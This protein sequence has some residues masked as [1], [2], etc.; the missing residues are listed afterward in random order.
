[1]VKSVKR[2]IECNWLKQMPKLKLK[3]K[4]DKTT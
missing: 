2:G 4:K 1:M 3:I